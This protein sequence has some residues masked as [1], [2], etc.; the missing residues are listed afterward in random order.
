[1]KIRVYGGPRDGEIQSPAYA[2][3]PGQI[4]QVPS[5]GYAFDGER[6]KGRFIHVYEFRGHWLYRGAESP[7]GK[8]SV[9]RE[10]E[11]GGK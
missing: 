7:S 10:P 1:M 4:W 5:E 2:P 3:I 8:I 6:V 11:C 9:C